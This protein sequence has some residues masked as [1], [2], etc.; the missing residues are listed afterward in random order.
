MRPAWRAA[1]AY[2][3]GWMGR[4]GCAI[5]QT[6]RRFQKGKGSGTEWGV[7]WQQRVRL[8]VQ[9]RS[10]LCSS[11]SM[12]LVVEDTHVEAFERARCSA[13]EP[14]MKVRQHGGVGGQRNPSRDIR[15]TPVVERHPPKP[16]WLRRQSGL[17]AR[18]CGSSAHSCVYAATRMDGRQREGARDD[19]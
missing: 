1:V 9:T 7:R 14:V 17:C 13:A 18:V 4:G 6:V 2:G 5:K 11:R 15:P 19:W 10:K 8:D 12:N 3:V 16:G